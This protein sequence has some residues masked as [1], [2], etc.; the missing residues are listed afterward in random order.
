MTC[1]CNDN[2]GCGGAC[3]PCSSNT[4]I[5]QAVNDALAAEKVTLEG[6][7][8]DSAN[9]A[10]E[11]AESAADAA[12]SASAAA[13]SQANAETA[14]NTATQAATSVTETA[15]V[16][17]ETAERIEQ[18]QDLLEEQISALQTKPVYFEVSTPTS[19]LV[20]PETESVF[21]VR[22]IYI[23]SARQ[24]VGYGF[25][26]DKDTRT[27]TLAEEITAEQIAETDEG[28]ILVEVIC[29]VYSSD[30]P[31]SFP[32][33]LKSTLGAS[34]VG[35]LDE[36]GAASTVA[37]ELVKARERVDTFKEDLAKPTGST[38]VGSVA[39]FA[40]LRTLTGLT[41]GQ[42]IKL[43]SY[44]ALGKTGDGEFIVREGTA[45]DDAGHICVPTGQSNIYLERVTDCVKLSDYGITTESNSSGARV[46]QSDKLQAAINRAKSLKYV[47]DT[48]IASEN[49][50]IYTGIYVEKGINIT[51][52]KTIRGCLSILFDS[53]KLVGITAPGYS[54]VAWAL[55]NLNAQFNT[56]GIVF[57]TTVGN[58]SFES[59]VVRDVSTRG[60]NCGGQLHVT[61]GTM[62]S[63]AL[64]ATDINGPGVWVLGSYDSV[65]SDVRSVNCGNVTQWAVDLAAY[66]GTRA[67]NTN[68]M[69]IGRIESHDSVDR[70]LRCSADL[71][72][73]GEIHIEATQV[74]SNEVST[75]ATI[76]DNGWGYANVLLAGLSST[77]G[78]VRDLPVVGSIPAILELVADDTCIDSLSM[79]R[80]SLSIHYAFTTPRGTLTA[81]SI[82]VAGNV[83]ITDGSNTVIDTL[84]VTGASSV[85]TSAST[86][87]NV[88]ILR[89]TGASSSLT[90]IGGR[91]GRIDCQ[92][93]TL[94]GCDVSRGSINALTL[95]DRNT[96]TQVTTQTLVVTGTR[97]YLSDGFRV[98]G[99]A[100]LAG[101][102]NAAS[103]VVFVGI[104]TLTD[105]WKFDKVY[106]NANLVYTGNT[107]S[108]LY[109][110]SFQDV[111]VA[112]DLVLSGACR[113]HGHNLRVI[114]L[115][116][117]TMSTGFIV[118]N[119]CVVAGGIEG[120]YVGSF[121]VPAIGSITQN[122]TTGV[123]YI[124]TPT[125]WKSLTAA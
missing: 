59:I 90:S 98:S 114:N 50:Y 117:G 96:L 44:Y 6:Y 3:D 46:D 77:Y 36:N 89:A 65:I 49:H 80:S 79:P 24:A 67:D 2:Y 5:K 18:A 75:S 26:F 16:L 82:T 32:L 91:Y 52:L 17:E 21:N 55:V 83:I 122:F 101:L 100:S 9:S 1:N 54:E 102:N 73:I 45:T 99:T 70:A 13:Q 61:S 22:S 125:G 81:G 28:Y 94:T 78:S 11:S 25:T 103:N 86:N 20:L 112:G 56:S 107:S 116:I 66:R 108:T 43:A 63:G 30:D 121:N 71:S 23:A 87:F 40:A 97:N 35:T 58:Q 29:D 51:G 95:I 64:C 31:T 15:V 85:I 27:V 34:L 12:S 88:G 53:T 76:A 106:I 84:T 104:V 69:T 60:A 115:R 57:G 33:V 93:V 123:P 74:T 120:N 92:T 19:S 42:K 118:L 8:T 124:Y 68:C 41:V 62:V 38:L 119:N 110:V 14:A 47:L 72:T 39:S 111:F 109:D 10:T 48:G 105:P 113:I 7:V 4:A 37:E